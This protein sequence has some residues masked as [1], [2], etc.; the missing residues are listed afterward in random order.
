MIPQSQFVESQPVAKQPT[1]FISKPTKVLSWIVQFDLGGFSARIV[2][3]PKDDTSY[4]AAVQI[5]F[6]DRV[7]SIRL[8][9]S[10]ADLSFNH[11]PHVR[12]IVPTES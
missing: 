4:W 9:I 1:Q 8:Q 7:Y 6:L 5:S 2:D 10:Y 11:M 3:S 12:N